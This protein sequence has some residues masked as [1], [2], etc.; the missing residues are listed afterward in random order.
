LVGDLEEIGGLADAVVMAAAG[1]LMGL[2]TRLAAVIRL[3]FLR[4]GYDAMIVRD[5]G[6]DGIDY[7]IALDG[8]IVR[9][10]EP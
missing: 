10:V 2:T 4:Q 6:G 8:S 9:V 7:V 3:E 1:R 5:A